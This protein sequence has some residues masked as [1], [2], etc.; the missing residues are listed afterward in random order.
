M[1]KKNVK[2]IHPVNYIRNEKICFSKIS[3]ALHLYGP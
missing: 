3:I 2:N 1:F